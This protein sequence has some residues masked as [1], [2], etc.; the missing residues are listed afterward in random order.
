MC[1]REPSRGSTIRTET[2]SPSGNQREPECTRVFVF[3]RSSP[4]LHDP[5]VNV[6]VTGGAGFIGSHVVERLVGDGHRV[7]V[8]DDFNDFY[9]PHRK[10]ANLAHLRK[11]IAIHRATLS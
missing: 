4:R 5:S 2:S 1:Q 6:L 11:R 3:A 7:A 10:E 8:L 9:D